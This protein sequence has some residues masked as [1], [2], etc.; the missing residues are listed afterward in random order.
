MQV[1]HVAPPGGAEDTRP[2]EEMSSL[3]AAIYLPSQYIQMLAGEKTA[4]VSRDELGFIVRRSDI[5]SVRAYVRESRALPVEYNKVVAWL[6]ADT[7][8]VA[9]LEPAS[10]Q[11]FHQRVVQHAA[12]WAVLER[13]TKELSRQLNRFSDG[14]ITT[15]NGIIELINKVELDRFLS[16]TLDELTQAEEAELKKIVLSAT[17]LRAVGVVRDYV[18]LIKQ[19]TEAYIKKNPCRGR[20]GGRV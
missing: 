5:Q 19:D 11:S 15:A 9:G 12:S 14:F 8:S 6:G 13:D 18:L 16:G 10:I 1:Q 3:E 17:E 2:L 7:A 4:A 20:A